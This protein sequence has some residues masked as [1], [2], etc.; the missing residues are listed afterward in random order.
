[1]FDL[2][3]DVSTDLAI[4]IVGIAV[5]LVIVG[6]KK[7]RE[8]EREQ[9]GPPRTDIQCSPCELCGTTASPTA[10]WTYEGLLLYSM[11]LCLPCALATDAFPY[12]PHPSTH[13]FVKVQSRPQHDPDDGSSPTF[14]AK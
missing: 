9:G 13:R 7:T 14:Q 1:M 8:R 12:K 2:S 5:L 11:R 4:L 3:A 6:V 10:D